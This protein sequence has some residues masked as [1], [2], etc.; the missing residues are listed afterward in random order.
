MCILDTG[1]LCRSYHSR[2]EDRVVYFIIGFLE[3]LMGQRRQLSLFELFISLIV[4]AI[5][6]TI[7]FSRYLD[8]QSYARAV[9]MNNIYG[10]MKTGA[11]LARAVCL[12]DSCVEKGGKANMSGVMIDMVNLYP[13]ASKDGIM[14]AIQLDL[15]TLSISG[16]NPLLIDF[17]NH[18]HAN[19][20]VTYTEAETMNAV[21]EMTINT[22]G[23]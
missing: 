15:E 6:S 5:L 13:A 16:K 10:A 1:I 2:K 21:P 20:R 19:C 3:M 12:I 22:T 8:F 4:I 11:T 7:L 14:N 23:C 18:S 17:R 9:Q